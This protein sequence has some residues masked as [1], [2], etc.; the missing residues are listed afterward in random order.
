MQ[1]IHGGKIRAMARKYGF[2]P[3]EMIDFSASINPL[4]LHENIKDA[5]LRNLDFIIHYPDPYYQ[6]LNDVLAGSLR[7]N[8]EN[9][10][11]LS[12][13]IISLTPF[14]Y[15]KSLAASQPAAHAREFIPHGSRES[16][17]ILTV[18]LCPFIFTECRGRY[19]HLTGFQCPRNKVYKFN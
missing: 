12:T 5:I 13:S 15:M 3:E 6:E 1:D 11:F 4:G 18:S 8:S 19:Q 10:K 16:F 17:N 14:I 7:I 9:K 2:R